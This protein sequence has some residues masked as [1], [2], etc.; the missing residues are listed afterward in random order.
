[1]EQEPE[2][3][4]ELFNVEQI[5]KIKNP[6][7]HRIIPKFIFSLLR[8]II[9]ENTLNGYNGRHWQ[10]DGIDYVAGILD[11]FQVKID[12]SVTGTNGGTLNDYNALARLFSPGKRYILASNH[13]LGGLDG[14]ALIYVAGKVR[15]DVVFPVN[16]LLLFIPSLRSIFIPINKHGKNNENV[17]L[18]DQ[19]F[20]S[21]K[22][23][24]FFPAGL[25]SRKQ[26]GGFIEDLEWKK[27]FITRAK[28][29]NRD[30]VPVYISGAN[31]NFFYS[32][33]RWRKRL[34]IKAN[35]EMLFLPQE[36]IRQKNRTIRIIFGEPVPVESFDKTKSDQEWAAFIKAKSYQLQSF[37]YL[38]SD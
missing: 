1:M 31:S 36:M 32:L 12:F 26:K 28:K 23:I 34:G 33:A 29:Y 9:H 35:L 18:I 15:P 2:K 27:T 25:V 11:D 3:R 5:I 37:P 38:Y 16:D 6:G 20:A 7:L 13:P 10:K 17:S 21:D 22:L 14:L 8:R 4:Q 24:L 19:T 30:I